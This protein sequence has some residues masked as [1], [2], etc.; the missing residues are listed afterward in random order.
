M[1]VPLF[2]RQAHNVPRTRCSSIKCGFV[3]VCVQVM[4]AVTMPLT[5]H[6]TCQ[7]A[8]QK[9]RLG[10]GFILHDTF[11]CAGGEVE[12]QDSCTGDGGSPL[13]CPLQSDFSR[14]VQ[15]RTSPSIPQAHP[16]LLHF[17]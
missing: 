3:C 7:A 11:L 16:P 14:Y 10:S 6:D 13:V 15:V 8:M 12:G 4:K 9:T 2:R 1:R 5:R 17:P